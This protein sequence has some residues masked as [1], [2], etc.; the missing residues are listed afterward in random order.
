MTIDIT[1][2]TNENEF[3]T[4]HYLSAILES[5]LKDVFSEWKR[6]EDEEEVPQPYTLLRGLRKD[7]FAALALL[8]KEK[9]IED[10]LTIQREFLADLLAGLGFQYHHQVVD[11][12]EDG[13]IP[14]IGGVAK[15]DGSPELWVIEALAGHEENLDPLELIFHQEQ[16]GLQEDDLKPIC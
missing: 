13:S 7:Y 1:G 6:K 11:L 16:Y 14:L 2:I 15:T 9:K 5:D 10:R 12:D 8:E 4:H 3:Y